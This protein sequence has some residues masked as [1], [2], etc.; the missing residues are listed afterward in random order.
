MDEKKTL[1]VVDKKGAWGFWRIAY[2][3]FFC[4]AVGWIWEEIYCLVKHGFW[5]ERGFLFGPILPIYGLG[6]ITI[7][8]LKNKMSDGSLIKL[9]LLSFL[10]AGVL[11]YLS[12]WLLELIFDKRWWDY[13]H[14]SLNL[15]GRVHFVGLLFF[16][17]FGCILGHF[18]FPPFERFLEKQN[19]RVMTVVGA[20]MLS[21]FT[22]DVLAS[23]I[24]HLVS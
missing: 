20:A 3:F 22:I 5:V 12:S 21:I 7:Y 1:S 6:G 10:G 15:N 19:K 16:G 23:G 18:V 13:T 4:A 17:A 8:W 24:Y 9:F 11:E 2:I 14:V